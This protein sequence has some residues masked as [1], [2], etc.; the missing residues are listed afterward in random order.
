VVTM[1]WLLVPPPTARADV[2]ANGGNGTGVTPEP[3]GK[4]PSIVGTAGGGVGRNSVTALERRCNFANQTPA[5][6]IMYPAVRQSNRGYKRRI[7]LLGYWW[8]CLKIMKLPLFHC[9]E[10]G[11]PAAV[12]G[13]KNRRLA[14]NVV[15]SPPFTVR[16]AAM[17]I[18]NFM[19]ASPRPTDA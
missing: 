19:V 3:S 5:L 14:I 12:R 11:S 18:P 1:C 2:A 8:G 7:C 4:S 17:S 13:P 9:P 6:G 16:R 15:S 10:N